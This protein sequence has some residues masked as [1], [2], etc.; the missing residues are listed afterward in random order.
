[1][2]PS[3]HEIQGKSPAQAYQAVRS[4][5]ELLQQLAAN[6]GDKDS[7]AKGLSVCSDG[8]CLDAVVLNRPDGSATSVQRVNRGGLTRWIWADI[9]NH[10]SKADRLSMAESCAHTS[11]WQRITLDS[12]PRG[13]FQIV[14]AGLEQSANLQ[15]QATAILGA[16][17]K[18]SR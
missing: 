3:I 8:Q 12:Y 9:P 10:E 13:V 11:E 7:L 4:R 15:D 18:S 1:M 16:V 14:Y 17:Q 2:L 5:L 6:R